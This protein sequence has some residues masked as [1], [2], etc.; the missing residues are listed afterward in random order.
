MSTLILCIFNPDLHF[1]ILAD[2]LDFPS[3]AILL[4]KHASGWHPVEHFSKHLMP[5][6]AN[7]S[8]TECELFC[9]LL[10]I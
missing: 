10:A 1:H 6:E 4:Q 9:C 7:Y 8:A 3:G 5:T 2:T